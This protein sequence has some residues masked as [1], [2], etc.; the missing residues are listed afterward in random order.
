MKGFDDFAQ[1]RMRDWGAP[2]V[3]IAVVKDGAVILSRG[4]GLRDVDNGPNTTTLG[5]QDESRRRRRIRLRWER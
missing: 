4:Y 3:A 1:S 5:G 2:G